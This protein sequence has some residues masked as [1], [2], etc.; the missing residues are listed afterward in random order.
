MTPSRPEIALKKQPRQAR[1]R[2]AMAAIVEAAAQLLETE[3]LDAV[4]T[5][6]IARRAGVS[7]GTLYQY[8]P[9][10]AAVLAQLLR[11][12]RSDLICEVEVALDQTEGAGLEVTVLALLQAAANH[13]LRR[14]R[15]GAALDYVERLLPVETETAHVNGAI[16]ALVARRLDALQ[17]RDPELAARDVSALARGMMDAA[18]LAGETDGPAVVGRLAPAVLG[19]LRARE[20]AQ[21]A[22]AE[23]EEEWRTRHDSNV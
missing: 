22:S 5:N 12:E 10:K 1:A 20:P 17:I 8:F 11:R 6:A 4:N 13:Q 7:I 21:V 16:A 2:A 3:G 18:G 23:D 9:S 15:L 19:Y 14:P